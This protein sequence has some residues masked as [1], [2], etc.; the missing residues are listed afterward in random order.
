MS[1]DSPGLPDSMPY[2]V[3]TPIFFSLFPFLYSIYYYKYAKK[4]IV[5]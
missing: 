1:R 3:T 5:K 2:Y 4:N